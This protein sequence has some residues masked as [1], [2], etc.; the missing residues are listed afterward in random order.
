VPAAM[1]HSVAL[2]TLPPLVTETAVGAGGAKPSA[3]TAALSA[4]LTLS[5]C[6][7]PAP[8]MTE[9]TV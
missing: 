1:L 2:V 7:P 8:V 3:V 5:T 9:R 6:A 4:L